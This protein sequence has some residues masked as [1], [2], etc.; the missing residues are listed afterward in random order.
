MAVS[1]EGG[2]SA[3]ES[4]APGKFSGADGWG[5]GCVSGGGKTMVVAG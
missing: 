3:L 1:Y 2:K 4:C 5:A